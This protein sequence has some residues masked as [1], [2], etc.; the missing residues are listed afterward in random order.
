MASRPSKLLRSAACLAETMLLLG[1]S[2]GAV[3]AAG[4]TLAQ[5]PPAGGS[6]ASPVSRAFGARLPRVEELY[7]N[8]V[9]NGNDTHQLVHFTHTEDTFTASAE[10]LRKLG[11]RLPPGAGAT[12]RLEDI[13]GLRLSYDAATQSIAITAPPAVLEQETARLNVAANPLPRPTASP[14]MLVNYDLYGA[15]DTNGGTN[16]SMFN[17]LRLFNALGVLSSTS[18]AQ[19]IGTPESGMHTNAVRLDTTFSRSFVDQATTLRAGDLISGS[20]SWS[21]ATRLG[22]IQWQRNFALQPNLVTFPVPAFFGQAAVPSTVDLYVQG[23]KRYSSSV[24]SGPFQL[25]TV[26]VVNGSGQAQVIVTDALGRQTSIAFPFY[27]SGQLLRPGLSDYSVEL[28]FLRQQYGLD[29][30]SYAS[31]PVASGTLR[32]GLSDWLTVEGH[33]EATSGLVD[34][35]VGADVQLWRAG[36]VNAAVAAS[37]DGSLDGRQIELGYSWRN[38][39]FNVSLDTL[40]SYGAYRD[41]ASRESLAPPRRA[42]RALAGLSVGRLGSIGVNYVALAYPGQPASRFAGAFYSTTLWRDVSFN[43]SVNQELGNGSNRSLF[44]SISMPFGRD[45]SAMA[46][47][48]HDDN[49]NSAT[50]DVAKPIDPDG[51]FGWHL[52]TQDGNHSHNGLAE[53]GYNGDHGQIIGGLQNFD[54]ETLGYGELTGSLV[55]IDRQMFL[56]RQIDD[57]FAV[58]ST[59]GVAKVPV[60]FENRPVGTTDA[61]GDLLL[62]RLNAYQGNKV[63]IDPMQLP[64]DLRIGSVDATVVPADRAGTV[65]QFAIQRVHAALVILHDAAGKPIAVGSHATL[66]APGASP[67]IVGYDGMAYVTGLAA[68][69]LLDVVTPTGRCVARFDYPVKARSVPRIGPLVCT[70]SRP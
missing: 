30:F 2:C 29:S 50:L 20:L 70:E 69:N 7:L 26:P 15:R 55:L 12:I 42:D 68:H 4:P 41:V 54:G 17:E 14:G 19:G 43:A 47:F 23:I 62:W 59:D 18:L 28:G 60:L 33:A 51:G 38:E 61:A 66:R 53:A 32:R 10:A 45:V 48:E 21:R 1:G 16:L 39:I 63:S 65:V 36:V 35:G 6:A 3:A 67:A 13:P 52:R 31:Q 9:L 27:T 56:A 22:G 46:A 49:S 11:F 25:N 44:I 40:R 8:V 58:V 64:T 24:P 57:A 37:H 34:G 5:L